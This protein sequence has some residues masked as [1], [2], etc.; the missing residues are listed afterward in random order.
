MFEPSRALELPFVF[1]D[2]VFKIGHPKIFVFR[3]KTRSACKTATL[4]GVLSTINTHFTQSPN[5]HWFPAVVQDQYS[6][7]VFLA[8]P[9]YLLIISE[10]PQQLRESRNAGVKVMQGLFCPLW[11]LSASVAGF[12]SS[13]NSVD[14]V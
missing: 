10:T 12:V 7:L 8:W 14:Q 5:N 13:N 1:S 11:H 3:G 4:M 2:L 9:Y 6:T